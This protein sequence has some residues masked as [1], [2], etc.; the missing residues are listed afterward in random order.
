MAST[1][2]IVLG[3]LQAMGITFRNAFRRATTL[4][5]PKEKR[6]LPARWRK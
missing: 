2:A 1:S 5:Y 4:R 6:T 3:T